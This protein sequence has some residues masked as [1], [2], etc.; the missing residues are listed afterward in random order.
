MS[1]P[2]IKKTKMDKSFRLFDFNVYND[3]KTEEESSDSEEEPSEFIDDFDEE[4]GDSYQKSEKKTNTFKDQN[5][6]MIQMFGVNEKGETCSI[7][8]EHFKPFFYVKV[9]DN[10]TQSKKLSF[11][12][13]IKKDIDQKYTT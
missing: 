11:L 7:I 2:K 8:A 1:K 5:I 12:A 10:W 4:Y 13:H 9:G 3:K 6:F